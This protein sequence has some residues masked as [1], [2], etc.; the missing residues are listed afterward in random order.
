MGC[1]VS[2]SGEQTGEVVS[3]CRERKRLIKSILDRRLAFAESQCKYNQSMLAVALAIKLFVARHSSPSSPFLITFP[4]PN[5]PT[6]KTIESNSMKFQSQDSPVSSISSKLEREN[7]DGGGGGDDDHNKV[8]PPMPPPSYDFGWEFFDL[9]DVVNGFSQSYEERENCRER[10]EEVEKSGAGDGKIGGGANVSQGEEMGVKVIDEETSGRELLEAL[11]DVEDYFIRVYESGLD[12]S[13]MLETNVDHLQSGLEEVKESP[14]KFV[15]SITRRIST[16]SQSSSSKSFLLPPSKSSSTCKESTNNLFEGNGGMESGIHSSTLGR[17]YAWEKKLYEQVKAGDEMRKI[18]VRKCSQLSNKDARGDVSGS[19]DKTRAELS[20]LYSRILVTMRSADSILKRM[21]NVRDQELQPQLLE[22]LHGLMRS[23][24][25]MF[26]SHQAQNQAISQVKSFTS[27]SLGN[28]ING[29][30]CLST[31]QLEAELQNWRACFSN[32]VFSQKS[33]VQALDAYLS[34]SILQPTNELSS[35]ITSQPLLD[36]CHDWLDLINNL[37]NKRITTDAMRIFAKD[38]RSLWVQQGVEEQQKLKVDGLVMELDRRV[39]IIEVETSDEKNGRDLRHRVECIQKKKAQLDQF[40][41]RVEE[42][43]AK[44]QES[45][46]ET[47]R[48]GLDSFRGGF[49]SVFELLT[50][51]SRACVDMY[52]VLV[53]NGENAKERIEKGEYPV[54]LEMK[55]LQIKSLS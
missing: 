53:A 10:E 36:I 45:M 9:F 3:L 13:K 33:Y 12:V 24:K 1:P 28:F 5:G 22:L 26:E 50:E 29:S 19:V 55:G 23:W 8:D 38:I 25:A 48:V 32:Y 18:Y 11:K 6:N 42:E 20:N 4:Q 35:Q 27:Q 34:K 21:K 39:K 51:F 47:L 43:K 41:N 44:H 52:T 15:E 40:K 14:N 16:S 17:L 30:H 49:S 2:K 54:C 31:L 7:E 37:P 46:Q